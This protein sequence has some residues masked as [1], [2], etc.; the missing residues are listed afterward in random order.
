MSLRH[1]ML[2]TV[3]RRLLSWAAALGVC[4]GVFAW[5]LQP[6]FLRTLADRLWSCF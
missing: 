2:P 3:A 5:Y 1:P 6:A 4:L